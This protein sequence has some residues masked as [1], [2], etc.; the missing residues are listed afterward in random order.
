MSFS[1]DLDFENILET[2]GKD[3]K[4]FMGMAPLQLDGEVVKKVFQVSVFSPIAVKKFGTN[5][6]HSVGVIAPTDLIDLL[7]SM[8][9]FLEGVVSPFTS[10]V[11]KVG[12]VTMFLKLKTDSKGKYEC[13]KTLNKN[14]LKKFQKIDV[15]LQFNVYF[16]AKDMTAGISIEVLSLK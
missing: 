1:V 12:L 9:K 2:F 16:N 11:K 6:V 4:K 10:N 15:E 3:Q 14:G 7:Q 5:E 8:D 13:N